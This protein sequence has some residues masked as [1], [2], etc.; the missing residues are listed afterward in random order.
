MAN[1]V[2]LFV[3]EQ[4]EEEYPW[5]SGASKC[6]HG[7]NAII[8]IFYSRPPMRW[9][10]PGSQLKVAPLLSD[11]VLDFEN[12][13]YWLH[14][15]IWLGI[16]KVSYGVESSSWLK[17]SNGVLFEHSINCSWTALKVDCK[18]PWYNK[19]LI[20]HCRAQRLQKCRAYQRLCE[21]IS[22]SRKFLRRVGTFHYG[23][24]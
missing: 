5:C 24:T 21:N 16:D 12:G 10:P 15:I 18:I 4:N 14:L 17:P 8:I 22:I 23:F 6:L 19:D 20:W 11:S 1:A 2:C 3:S 9:R 13:T 7:N